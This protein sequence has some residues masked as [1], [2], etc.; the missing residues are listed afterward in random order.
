MKLKIAIFGLSITS[1]WGNGHATTYRA[2]IKALSRRGHSVTFLERDVPWYRDHRDV[3]QADYCRICLYRSLPELAE[4]HARLVANADLVILGSYVPDGIAIGDWVTGRATGVTAFYDI[5]TP[6]T[7]T[8]LEAGGVDYI[9]SRLIPRFDIYL[10]FTGGPTLGLIEEM[11]GAAAARALYCSADLDG[12]APVR[13]QPKW[14]LGYLGTYSED[15]QPALEQLM[16]APARQLP[17]Q[18]FIVAGSKYPDTL[19]WP[20]NVEHVSHLPPGDHAQFYGSQRF[21]LNVTRSDMKNL[22]FSPSVRL[23][24]AAVSGAP[25]ISDNWPGIESFFK[26][27]DEL[28]IADSARD[29][30]DI[31][32]H[33]PEDRR[34]AIAAQA[35]AR[36]L[37]E[38]TPLHRAIQLE[39]YYQEALGQRQSIK[40]V[41]IRGSKLE[42]AK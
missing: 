15:R 3:E 36:L 33:M 41:R 19:Y 21:T 40:S 10:S 1:S 38:H 11:Y 34:L 37:A 27:G 26:P 12:H 8:G 14:S 23:F 4:Q 30:V 42:E 2:L 16:L 28:L 9:S 17:D 22:G 24:E 6:V 5:D 32:T 25:I 20:A 29:V 13:S 39:A 18:A 35:R 31:L 7:L